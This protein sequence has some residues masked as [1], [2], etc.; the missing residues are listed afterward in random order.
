MHVELPAI[1]SA[2]ETSTIPHT[3]V[4]F[5]AVIPE[6]GYSIELT[7]ERFTTI[8]FVAK[9]AQRGV[10]LP[11]MVGAKL[12]PSGIVCSLRLLDANAGRLEGRI[13]SCDRV[14][15]YDLL[16]QEALGSYKHPM[17][18]GMGMG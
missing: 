5:Q 7:T 4:T 3:P 11:E 1:E 9:I 12:S 8:G 6:L 2:G 13:S 15:W 14:A 18:T 16:S 10:L 17:G